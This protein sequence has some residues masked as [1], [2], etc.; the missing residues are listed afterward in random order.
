MARDLDLGDYRNET[1][2]GILHHVAHLILREETAVGLAVLTLVAAYGRRLAD[3]AHLGQAGIFLNLDTPALVLGK[4][5]VETVDLVHGEYVDH[6]LHLVDAEYV[7]SHVEHE[8]AVGEVGLV[9]DLACGDGHTCGVGLECRYGQH[10]A[11]RL[12]GVEY[13]V[14]LL[15]GDLDARGVDLQAVL[16]VAER[17]VA[18]DV[19]GTLERSFGLYGLGLASEYLAGYTVPE[20]YGIGHALVAEGLNHGVEAFNMKAPSDV[21]T[22]AGRGTMSMLCSAGTVLPHDAASSAADTRLSDRMLFNLIIGQ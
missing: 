20:V 3:A 13:A 15:G 18:Y 10:L 1:L 11:Q 19:D 5:P 16:L 9:V 21:V 2:G 7:A 12:E 4:V 22:D 17:L 8:A 14:G 6:V